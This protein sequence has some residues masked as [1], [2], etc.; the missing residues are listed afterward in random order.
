MQDRDE[1]FA[2]NHGA[3]LSVEEIAQRVRVEVGGKLC[4]PSSLA[5]LSYEGMVSCMPLKENICAACMSGNYVVP[6]G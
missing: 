5:Y 6:K 4:S 2:L 3:Q 1:L